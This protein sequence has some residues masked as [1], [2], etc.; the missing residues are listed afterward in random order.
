MWI[1]IASLGVVIS[2]AGML[3]VARKW[4]LPYRS[5]LVGAIIAAL[6]ALI[7]FLWVYPLCTSIWSLVL[8]VI[9]QIGLAFVFALSAIL[10]HFWRD[11]ERIPPQ[12]KG[13]IVSAA[14]GEVIYIKTIP[15]GTIPLVTK[16][17]R[18]YSLQEL[19][20]FELDDKNSMTIIGIEMNILNVHVNR[21]PIGGEVKLINHIS[22]KFISL[23][24][25]DAPF[26]NTR[27]T[28]IITNEELTVVTVQIASRLVRRVDNYLSLGQTASLGD[29]LGMIRFGSQAAVIFPNRKD[30]SIDTYIG[31]IVSA[32]TSILAHYSQ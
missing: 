26:V 7:P 8:S 16:N 20:G 19:V 2:I 27:C 25:K 11:P 15:S 13:V 22:G 12:E 4:N 32:G 17:G 6:F 5:I 30:I 21:C 14:D 24:K 23:R 29:R 1:V 18:D 9:G 3:L 28:T 31:Q 10:F